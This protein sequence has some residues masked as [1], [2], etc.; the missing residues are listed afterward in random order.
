MSLKLTCFLIFLLPIIVSAQEFFPVQSVKVLRNNQIIQ[1]PWTLG[2]NAAHVNGLDLDLDGAEDI[3]VFEKTS[4]SLLTF[5]REGSSEF[6]YDPGFIP[7]LPTINHWFLTRDINGDG[8]KDIFTA[9]PLGIKVYLNNL[10]EGFIEYPVAPLLTE[11]SIGTINIFVSQEDIPAIQDIDNDGDLDIVNFQ[12]SGTT[13]EWHKNLQVEENLT[14]TIKFEKQTD[15]WGSIRICSCSVFVN[16]DEQCPPEG[17]IKHATGH[18]LLLKD[19]DGDGDLDLI[20]SDSECANLHLLKNNGT[21]VSPD[22]EKNRSSF[23]SSNI[24]MPY[25]APFLI[26]TDQDGDEDLVVGTNYAATNTGRVDY[27][28]SMW[29]FTNDRSDEHP[30]F[31]FQQSNFLQDQ[32]IDVGQNSNVVFFDLDNDGD[33]DMIVSKFT[34]RSNEFRTGFSYYENTGSY[35]EPE[36]NFITDDLYGLS[37]FMLY[38]LKAQ[39]IDVTGDRKPDFVFSGTSLTN[40]QTNIYYLENTGLVRFN[41]DL[42]LKTLVSGLPF[43]SNYLLSDIFSDGKLDL[44]VTYSSRVTRF[45]RFQGDFTVADENFHSLPGSVNGLEIADIDNDNRLDLI[46]SR[47]D[48]IKIIHDFE[49]P[50]SEETDVKLIASKEGDALG[51]SPGNKLQITARKILGNNIPELI[52]GNNLGGITILKSTSAYPDPIEDPLTIYPNP[53]FPDNNLKLQ[54]QRNLLLYILNTEGKI[55]VGPTYLPAFEFYELTFDNLAAGMYIIHVLVD[56]ET[57]WQRKFVITK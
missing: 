27:K 37:G 13:L 57:S 2:I 31:N 12:L 10:P 23:L 16:S 25:P 55:L 40:P 38:N 36:F 7:R 35:S 47:F 53:L 3:I 39:F 50:L 4:S 5:I 30:E 42:E 1:N 56:N 11:T 32:M 14:D 45:E 52:I 29:L 41:T 9:D 28:N 33:E 24:F 46:Y 21:S 44:L 43:N 19:S 48:E 26:D 15:Q 8:K 22:F 51:Q 18:A 17:R 49:N 54:S 6:R 20:F 34:D